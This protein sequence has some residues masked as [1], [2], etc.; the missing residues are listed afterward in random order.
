MVS[1]PTALLAV[2]PGLTW[3]L[4]TPGLPQ[5]TLQSQVTLHPQ[6][7]LHHKAPL[8]LRLLRFTD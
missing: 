2:S 3:T 8:P 6:A 5:A 1:N 4:Y 7:T